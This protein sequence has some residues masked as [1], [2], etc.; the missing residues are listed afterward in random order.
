VAPDGTVAA[1]E[2]I[3]VR[4]RS[5]TFVRVVRNPQAD[6]V[7]FQGATLDDQDVQPGATATSSFEVS[8]GRSLTA[9]WRFE[10]SVTAHRLTLRY[11]AARAVGVGEDHGHL[12]WPLLPPG[13]DYPI[14]STDLTF[15][16]PLGATLYATA[17]VEPGWAMARQGDGTIMAIASNIAPG[18]GATLQAEFSVDP[19]GM[20][21]AVWQLDADR[22]FQLS[23]AWV[24]GALFILTIGAG[25]IWML[26][27]RAQQG[28]AD[29]AS[30]HAALR[31]TGLVS[32]LASALAF[33][34][35]Y[36]GMERF[37]V[38]VIAVPVSMLI[39]GGLFVAG[40]KWV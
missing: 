9:R 36:L 21:E 16:P 31:N 15:R 37:G 20:T 22:A 17:V 35:A 7:V 14:G 40:R 32:I 2:R 6:Q 26:R 18:A 39:V 38:L 10:P 3:V 25:V 5:G 11:Y 4:S 30:V 12:R 1:S 13:R 28:A 29:R 19:K 24:A 8:D 23:F 27:F 33:W 34:V